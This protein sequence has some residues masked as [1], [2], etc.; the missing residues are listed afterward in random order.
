MARKKWYRRYRMYSANNEAKAGASERFIRAFK[1]E[2]YK[3]MASVSRNVNI[4]NLDE[5]VNK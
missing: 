2:I 5:I 3:Y 4:V 1:N